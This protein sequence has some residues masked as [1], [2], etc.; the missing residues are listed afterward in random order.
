MDDKPE[1]G[2]YCAYWQKDWSEDMEDLLSRA[3]EL[4][5][6]LLELNAAELADRSTEYFRSLARKASNQSLKLVFCIGLGAEH[7]LTSENKEIRDRGVKYL[8]NILKKINLAGANK[9]SGLIYA[10]WNPD[11]VDL[12]PEYISRTKQY[13]IDSL[14]R[15]LQTAE[16]EEI[17]LNIEVVNRFEQFLLNTASQARSYCHNF[18]SP[19]LQIHLDTFHMNIEEDSI[20]E[21][22]IKTGENL[23]HLHVGENNRRPPG[24]CG[25]FDWDELFSALAAIEY[26]GDIVMEPFV[27]PGGTVAKDVNLWRNLGDIDGEVLDLR[28]KEAREFMEDK[29]AQHYNST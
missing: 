28:I 19:Y 26:T 24:E 1:I 10:A 16:R 3:G 17:I 5:F 27:I 23:G 8:Q 13:S 25:V 2:V 9:L 7:D 22:V 11:F 4:G 18:D 29:I 21:A 12:T 15:V 6:D 20:Y 14:K